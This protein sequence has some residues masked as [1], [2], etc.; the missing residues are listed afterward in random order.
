MDAKPH[1]SSSQTDGDATATGRAADDLVGPA[2]P[3]AVAPAV[4]GV[5]PAQKEAGRPDDVLHRVDPVLTSFWGAVRR[6][7]RYVR[8]AANLAADA[9]VPKQAKAA[10]VVGGAYTVS[11]VDLVPGIIPVAGQLDDLF[12]L[13]LAVR[14]ALRS[15][16]PGVAEEHLNRVTL[17]MSDLDD[18]LAAVRGTARWLAGKVFR[19]GG[20]FAKGTVRL[21]WSAVRRR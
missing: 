13:L 21:L 10:L 5:G 7:P 12:V 14:Q 2:D 20:R 11:P 19:A 15:C 9:R 3:A 4:S 1:I 6:L 8:L 17:A 16:P 18:D